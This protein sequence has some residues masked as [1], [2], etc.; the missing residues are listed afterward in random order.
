MNPFGYYFQV[1]DEISQL[2]AQHGVGLHQLGV[3]ERWSLIHV[4]SEWV[5]TGKLQVDED[6]AIAS[7]ICDAIGKYSEDNRV[8]VIEAIVKSIVSAL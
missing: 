4:L 7:K 2:E 5:I 1:P 3:G 6:W 8:F